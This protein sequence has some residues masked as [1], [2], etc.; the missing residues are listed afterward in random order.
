MTKSQHLSINNTICQKNTS[1]KH[2]LQ[3][4]VDEKGESKSCYNITNIEDSRKKNEESCRNKK[5]PQVNELYIIKKNSCSKNNTSIKKSITGRQDSEN[6]TRS[7]ADVESVSFRKNTAKKTDYANNQ[8]GAE[9]Q[10]TTHAEHSREGIDEATVFETAV[11]DK[12]NENNKNIECV[13]DGE[14]TQHNNYM[15]SGSK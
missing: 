12:S 9:V 3:E 11:S 13:R 6:N 14:C 7:L 5:N 10:E 4:N 8:I 1:D 2:G 15:K